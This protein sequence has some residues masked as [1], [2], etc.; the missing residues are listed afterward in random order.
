MRY[1]L[2]LVLLYEWENWWSNWLNNLFKVTCFVSRGTGT[3]IQVSLSQN[4]FLITIVYSLEKGLWQKR[5][6]LRK[7]FHSGSKAGKLGDELVLIFSITL[8]RRSLPI[9][10][11]VW[12]LGMEDLRRIWNMWSSCSL[13]CAR[14][15]AEGAGGLSAE[16]RTRCIWVD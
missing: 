14:E 7:E 1:G 13:L 9:R 11:E 3:Q 15:S 5:I 8:G 6:N 2:F 16:G 10:N 4:L 12:A